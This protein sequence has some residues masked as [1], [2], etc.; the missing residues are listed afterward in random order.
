MNTRKVALIAGSVFLAGVALT[1]CKEYEPGPA[2]KVVEKD[3]DA[4]GK[5]A[6]DYDL[7]VLTP[8][9]ERVEFEVSKEHYDRCYNGSKYPK[10]TT[11]DR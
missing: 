7:T 2:G 5:R 10:C 9:G 1:G 3:W 6:D 4:N 8:N 11:I